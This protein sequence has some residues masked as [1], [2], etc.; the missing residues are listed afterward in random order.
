M[1][2]EKIIS[3]LKVYFEENFASFIDKNYPKGSVL[4]DGIRYALE[5]KGKRVRPLLVLLVNHALGGK[6]QEALSAAIALEMMHTYSL[7]HDDMPVL[8]D[9]DLR[10]GRKT[11]HV[12]FDEPTA[13]LVGNSLLTDA[14]RVLTEGGFGI[15]NYLS[16]EQKV[17]M[18]QEL[19]QASG[20]QGMVLGQ[21]LD[22]YWTKK[23]DFTNEDLDKIHLNK[24]GK[25][26]G[27]ACAL[28]A[29]S[30]TS[31]LDL[32]S[33]LRRSGELLG[34][35]FQIIDDLLDESHETGKS[36]GKDKEL[37]KLTY[38]KV[39]NKI[40]SKNKADLL[41]Q[42]ALS[43]LTG[44]QSFEDHEVLPFFY[45]QLLDRKK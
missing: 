2:Q 18:V 13:L 4:N 28:G 14:F 20:S 31:N 16:D 40:E 10:R 8:D 17:R 42:K 9:D 6:K 43:L 39:Y 25:L 36:L 37:G 41:S 23:N 3:D 35:S 29:L 7:V 5:G 32:V 38:L 45:S 22:V 24:T 27:G 30:Y 1:L 44:I 26:L 21:A 19:S 12:V 15:K 34:L 11:V 33:K